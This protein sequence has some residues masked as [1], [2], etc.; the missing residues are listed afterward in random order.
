M[1]AIQDTLF[2]RPSLAFFGDSRKFVEHLLQGR[3][4]N[5]FARQIVQYREEQCC[6]FLE[7]QPDKHVHPG[8]HAVLDIAL[9]CKGT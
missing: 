4:P 5:W 1:Y 8:V 9:F 2:A 3:T 6:V 7:H